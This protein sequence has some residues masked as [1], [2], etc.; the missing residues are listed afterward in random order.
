[1]K[2]VVEAFKHPSGK[3]HLIQLDHHIGEGDNF[4]NWVVLESKDAEKATKEILK[5]FGITQDRSDDLK[6]GEPAAK[7][8]IESTDKAADPE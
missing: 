5:S 7:T 1:M 8:K 3:F 6:E 4:G 2:D